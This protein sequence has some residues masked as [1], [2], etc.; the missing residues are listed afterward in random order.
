MVAREFFSGQEIA[1]GRKQLLALRQSPFSG[2]AAIF[3][4]YA[5]AEAGCFLQLGWTPQNFVDLFIEHRLQTNGLPR[6]KRERKK[7]LTVQS[8]KAQKSDGRDSLLGALALRGLAHID[9]DEKSEMRQLMLSE[10]DDLSPEDE[11]RGIEYCRSD[12]VG[13]EALFRYMY[14]R[15]QIDWPRAL[16]RGRYAI[17]AARMERVG[18]PI[19]VPLHCRLSENWPRL[20]HELI[21][22]V[23]RT[24]HVFD[25]HDV[26]KREL[27]E[28]L[29]IELNIPWPKVSSGV[30]ATDG[31]TF[32]EMARFHPELRPLY[33]ALSSLG[34]TR[35][36]GLN[37][38]PDGRNRCLLSIFGT[39]TSRNTPSP[40]AFIYGPARWMRG[41][42]K[43]P[44][45]F[46]I[47]YADWCSQ[48]LVI[49]G[50]LS[51]CR[52]TE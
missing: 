32:D 34:E 20:R 26:F 5:S 24:F 37:I 9:V 8:G 10:Q 36:T 3:A 16:W 15:G 42:I 40:S 12:V 43:P 38:G 52:C 31:D 19:D 27:L 49:S 6:P 46:G 21:V 1:L 41:L 13:T 11:A 2:D 50:A 39:I 7:G 33:E 14:E 35:L 47:S 45:G 25:E 4:Y 17:A 30:L 29:V 51:G 23:N 28:A 48:E 44:D 18:V 22:D